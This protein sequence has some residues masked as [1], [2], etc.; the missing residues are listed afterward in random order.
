MIR[1]RKIAENALGVTIRP[2]F[3]LP[4][5]VVMTRSI[6]HRVARIDRADIHTE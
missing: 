5:N 1:S 2:P 4:A 3:G 6:S